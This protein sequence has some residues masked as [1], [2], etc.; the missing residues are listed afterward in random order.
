MGIRSVF[1]KSKFQIYLL[2]AYVLFA[3]VSYVGVY[4]MVQYFQERTLNATLGRNLLIGSSFAF[5][6]FKILFF[7]FLVIDDILRILNYIFQ[8]F[9]KFLGSTPE[10]D[11]EERRKFIVKYQ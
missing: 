9:S 3:V 11:F 10:A 2:I 4:V 1:T 5:I 7:G 8:L 6:I